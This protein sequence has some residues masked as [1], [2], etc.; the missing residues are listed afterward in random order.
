METL[1]LKAI[2]ILQFHCANGRIILVIRNHDCTK[3]FSTN[4]VGVDRSSD[5]VSKW[6]E[7]TRTGKLCESAPSGASKSTTTPTRTGA[8]VVS[9]G[10]LSYDKPSPSK[11]RKYMTDTLDEAI[12]RAKKG[13]EC[14]S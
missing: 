14:T 9:R 4:F 13:K 1:Q 11:R 2:S 7:L 12:E 6:D 5:F 8:S 3:G 10:V